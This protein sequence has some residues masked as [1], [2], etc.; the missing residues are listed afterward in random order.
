MV[1]LL[2]EAGD[3]EVAPGEAQT[4]EVDHL[5]I[6]KRDANARRRRERVG[7]GP[8]PC[9]RRSIR[10]EGRIDRGNLR[11][12]NAQLARKTQGSSSRR[13]LTKPRTVLRIGKRG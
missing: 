3:G 7:N 8:C 5:A 11:G 13:F 2:H 12:V 9:D 6:Q 4:R 1:R 10:R